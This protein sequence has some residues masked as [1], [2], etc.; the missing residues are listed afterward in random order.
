MQKTLARR[1]HELAAPELQRARLSELGLTQ[2]EQTT[3]HPL[4]AGRAEVLQINVGRRCNQVC[5]HC[6]VDAG[7]DRTEVMSDEV[8]EACL[9]MLEGGTFEAIDITGGAPE[10]HPR[11]SEII[12]RA[13]ASG[14]RVMHR[15]NLTAIRLPAY[16]HLPG[17]FARNKVE[18]IASL[19]V[20][21]QAC[22]DSQRGSGVYDESLDSLRELNELG[23]GREG[24]GLLLDLV[25][26][27]IGAA[28]PTGQEEL[29]AQFREQLRREYGIE[30]NRLLT[31]TNMPISRFLEWLH[32]KG[33]LEDYMQLL[34]DSFNPGTV[35]SVMCR[36]TVSIGPDGRVFD[37]DFNQMLEIPA[38]LPSIL[39]L[40]PEQFLERLE[41]RS[42][43]TGEHC[44]GCTAG[45]G[46]GCQ[47]AIA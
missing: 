1:G 20:L 22:T 28:L 44:Y 12:E 46:S 33:K 45:A 16:R 30:F 34:V 27:P 36:T 3:G 32:D 38:A 24:S 7:P 6:H 31:I 4:E 14:V 17:L 23:Y 37:C 15:C 11:F 21:A 10:L 29:E 13:A 9:A 35:D 25:S 41:G 47:G 19:P 39:D 43:R 26:N 5:A 18:I 2:F 8:V 42:I 40:P